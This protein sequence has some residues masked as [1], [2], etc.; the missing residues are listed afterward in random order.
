MTQGELLG[1][2]GLES[3]EEAEEIFLPYVND[4]ETREYVRLLEQLF[5]EEPEAPESH[6]RRRK[7]D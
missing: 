7:D 6:L 5:K 3:F 4:P 2:L 1:E